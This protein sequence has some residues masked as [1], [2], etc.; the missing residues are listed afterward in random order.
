MAHLLMLRTYVR[1]N[2][3]ITNFKHK[4][5]NLIGDLLILGVT[6][7]DALRSDRKYPPEPTVHEENTQ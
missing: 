7:G 6:S 2:G 4:L 3:T 5:P 1:T